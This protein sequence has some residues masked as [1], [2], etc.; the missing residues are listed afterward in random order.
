MIGKEMTMDIQKR[1]GSYAYF[2]GGVAYED[3]GGW[4]KDVWDAAW[5]EQQKEID[6][7]NARIKMLEEEV[8]FVEH[9]YNRKPEGEMK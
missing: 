8:A 4:S 7:L 3:D 6:A 5:Q 1:D 2:I 9:G